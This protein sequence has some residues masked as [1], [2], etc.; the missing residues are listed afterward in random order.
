MLKGNG[1]DNAKIVK[2]LERKLRR[3]SKLYYRNKITITFTS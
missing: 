1:K 2:K 3:L